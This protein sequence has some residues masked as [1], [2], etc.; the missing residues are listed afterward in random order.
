[1]KIAVV[2]TK[3]PLPS[4]AST[5]S[6]MVVGPAKVLL[7]ESTRVPAPC[8]TSAP[9]PVMA[10]LSVRVWPAPTVRSPLTVPRTLIETDWAVAPG[11]SSSDRCRVNVPSNDPRT[12]A[13]IDTA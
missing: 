8:L 5:P 10:L 3:E 4:R 12:A 6:E 11:R 13:A 2:P 9:V 7:A 1:M